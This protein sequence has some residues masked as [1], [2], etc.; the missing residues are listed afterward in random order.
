MA[1]S[2]NYSLR[3]FTQAESEMTSVERVLHFAT[4]LPEERYGRRWPPAAD[5][6]SGGELRAQQQTTM[7]AAAATTKEGLAAAAARLAAAP[8]ANSTGT[9][10]A[11]LVFDAV[12][13]FK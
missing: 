4:S 7:T 12:S 1:R 2:I 6:R 9:A 8:A 10:A 13:V 3:T 11:A 5:G